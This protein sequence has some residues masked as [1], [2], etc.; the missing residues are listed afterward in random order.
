MVSPC[1]PPSGS[2]TAGA[3]PPIAVQPHY[4]S[5]PGSSGPSTSR[6]NTW[7]PGTSPGMTIGVDRAAP[8]GPGHRAARIGDRR[9]FLL[10]VLRPWC[11]RLRHRDA[12]DP[13]LVDQLV[14]ETEM[15]LDLRAFRDRLGVVP[16]D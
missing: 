11:D 12:I 1:S 14:E 15:P 6:R 10:P 16:D 5:W 8:L 7:I 13:D 2:A 9:G 4:S 3:E